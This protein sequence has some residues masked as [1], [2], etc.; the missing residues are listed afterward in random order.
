[1]QYATNLSCQLEMQDCQLA[2]R[3]EAEQLRKGVEAGIGRSAL[4][5]DG[6]SAGGEESE[7]VRSLCGRLE[8]GAKKSTKGA[9][10]RPGR[11]QYATGGRD[12]ER[13]GDAGQ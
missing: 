12:Q 4:R 9:G 8:G 1:V 3:K 7:R 10:G 11:R 2:G 6:C 13:R 5:C